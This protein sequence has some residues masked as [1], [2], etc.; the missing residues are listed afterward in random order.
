MSE[1]PLFYI[2][3]LFFVA[4]AGSSFI[5]LKKVQSPAGLRLL[6][7]FSAAY[8]LGLCLLHLFPEMYA[9]GIEGAGWYVLGG[10]L[11]QIILDFFSHGIEHGHAHNEHRHHHGG[12]QFLV[13]VMISL[14]IHAFIEG[15]PFGAAWGGDVRLNLHELPHASVQPHNH[16]HDSRDS[17][18]VGIGLHKLTEAFVFASL[19]LSTTMSRSKAW[20]WIVLFAAVAPAGAAVQFF[21]GSTGMVNLAEFTPKITGVLIGIMLHISTTIIF[22][23]SEGHSFNLKKFIAII[24]GIGSSVLAAHHF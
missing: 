17:L 1:F 3:I 16:S 19:L 15:M 22:E 7:S 6:L 5:F 21:L 8:L 12:T 9:S 18:L 11:L 4:I 20:I 2:A 23:S 24:L 10:F 14:W 13:L